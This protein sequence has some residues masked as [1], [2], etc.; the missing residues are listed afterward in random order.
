MRDDKTVKS[1]AEKNKVQPATVMLSWLLMKGICPI[2]K[3]VTA[4]R[5][6]SNFKSEP[7]AQKRNSPFLADPP[8]AVDLSDEDFKALDKLAQE[9]PAKRVCDQSEGG[10]FTMAVWA[11]P[12]LTSCRS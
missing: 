10:L 12:K 2:P 9:T 3:S 4:S 6:E 8:A 5:I 1:I 11:E 7:V